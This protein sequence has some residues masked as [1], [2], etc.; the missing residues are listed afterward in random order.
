M[1][2]RTSLVVKAGFFM[3]PVVM[4]R[5][6]SWFTCSVVV[7]FGSEK[8]VEAHGWCEEEPTQTT[9]NGSNF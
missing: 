3:N 6:W 7:H 4:I 9:I 8:M 5:A 1:K 2:E